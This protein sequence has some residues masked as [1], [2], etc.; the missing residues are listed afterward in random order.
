MPTIRVH[1]FTPRCFPIIRKPELKCTPNPPFFHPRETTSRPPTNSKAIS[2]SQRCA[3]SFEMAKVKGGQRNKTKHESG[4]VKTVFHETGSNSFETFFPFPHPLSRARSETGRS[5]R[6]RSK[7]RGKNNIYRPPPSL[8]L[9]SLPIVTPEPRTRLTD[10]P[11][12]W[13]I[14][15]RPLHKTTIRV[16]LL[17]PPRCPSPPSI[18]RSRG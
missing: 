14:N 18:V 10:P 2:S 6:G 7:D 8:L 16:A 5:G 9:R 12:P 13:L 11:P 1:V 15:D 3:P 17:L 4:G